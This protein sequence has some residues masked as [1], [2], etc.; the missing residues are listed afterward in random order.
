MNR[1]AR[2]TL[3]DHALA[4]QDKS[5][6]LGGSNVGPGE[7][8]SVDLAYISQAIS[9]CDIQL[10]EIAHCL[11]VDQS[12]VTRMLNGEKPFPIGKLCLLPQSVRRRYHQLGAGMP[13]PHTVGQWFI[14]IGE[15]LCTR[16]PVKANRLAKAGLR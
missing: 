4:P 15:G 6:D 13:D 3:A 2:D 16:M 11:G 1:P 8:N 14:A 5:L 12:Y 7:V 9:D 10:K